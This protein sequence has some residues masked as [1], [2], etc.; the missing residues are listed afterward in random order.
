MADAKPK[1]L[2]LRGGAKL[3]LE[4]SRMAD[5]KLML[6]QLAVIKK[7]EHVIETEFWRREC[8]TEEEMWATLIELGSQR[9]CALAELAP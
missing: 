6:K 9:L 1:R 8:A 7:G 5:N 2:D 4:V 3:R